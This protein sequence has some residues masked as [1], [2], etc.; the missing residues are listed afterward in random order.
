MSVAEFDLVV[1]GGGPAGYV[2][3]I[4]GGQTWD[5]GCFSQQQP[6]VWWDLLAGRLH[7]KQSTVGVESYLP[8]YPEGFVCSRGD[9][10]RRQA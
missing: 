4:R 7:S 6:K 5:A 2:A 1:M 9:R 10:R 3:A 8:R